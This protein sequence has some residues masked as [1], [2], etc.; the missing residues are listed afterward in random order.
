MMGQRAQDFF[1]LGCFQLLSDKGDAMLSYK[2]DEETLLRLPE[3]RYLD[4]AY[5]LVMENLEHLKAWSTWA[6]DD[7]SIEDARSFIKTNLQNFAE[8]KGFTLHIIY[9]GKHVGNVGYNT[10][11]W[12]NKRTEIGYWLSASAQGKGL[13]T[14]ACRALVNHAFNELQLNRVEINCA[15]ENSRSRRI[16]EKLGFKQEGI[17]R[18]AEWLHDHFH[19]LVAYSMLASEWKLQNL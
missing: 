9:Q 14:K 3:E 7:F 11:D 8:R 10:I 5:A 19:D 6:R 12:A 15:V 4:E 2:I 13:M 16:P 18:E 1:I 17:M